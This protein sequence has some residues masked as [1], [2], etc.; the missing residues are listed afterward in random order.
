[1]R[2]VYIMRRIAQ[3]PNL[4]VET[5]IG[6]RFSQYKSHQYEPD[7]PVKKTHASRQD[8]AK[9]Y[10]VSVKESWQ[11]CESLLRSIDADY[12]CH[13]RNVKHWLKLGGRMHPWRVVGVLDG[14]GSFYLVKPKIV[15]R[16]GLKCTRTWFSKL[17]KMWPTSFI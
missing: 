14:D 13:Q 10:D 2:N 5:L 16:P 1:M 7:L 12:Q 17:Q 9:F 4:P 3:Q 15:F 11:S 8:V 6:L